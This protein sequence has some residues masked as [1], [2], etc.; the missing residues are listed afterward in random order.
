MNTATDYQ[1]SGPLGRP[2]ALFHMN[3]DQFAALPE[4]EY[5]LELLNGVV[6]MSPK[7]RPRHQKFIAKLIAA[8]DQWTEQRKLGDLFPETE[9]RVSDDWTPAPDLSFLKAEHL[10][11]VGET[12]ILGPVD[13][14]IEVVS[15][16]N[17]TTDRVDK[18]A[19]YAR[20]GIDWYWIVDLGLRVL[21]EY[22]RVGDAYLNPVEV[23]FDRPFSPR[24]FPELTLDLARLAR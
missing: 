13:L 5:S 7:P 15:P 11:R 9:M 14:A 6:V 3:S 17:E 24:V 20:F 22:E 16:S 19:A 18:F 12:Q 1:S 4:S 21:E 2:V 10:D 23:Q 8:L